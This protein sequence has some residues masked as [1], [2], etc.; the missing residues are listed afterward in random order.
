MTAGIV[1]DK[2]REVKMFVKGCLGF[3]RRERLIKAL[4]FL[5]GVQATPAM[6]DD[7]AFSYGLGCF[8]R[9]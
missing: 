2:W 4:P 6:L 1:A 5:L 3:E 7:P 8:P 9:L